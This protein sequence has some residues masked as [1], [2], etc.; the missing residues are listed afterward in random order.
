M[1]KVLDT[2]QRA[3]DTFIG[4]FLHSPSASLFGPLQRKAME[5]PVDMGLFKKYMVQLGT[6]DGEKIREALRSGKGWLELLESRV[7]AVDNRKSGMNLGD[8]GAYVAD[9][10]LH[11]ADRMAMTYGIAR[12]TL[13]NHAEALGTNAD[14]VNAAVRLRKHAIRKLEP[15]NVAERL[16]KD[17]GCFAPAAYLRDVILRREPHVTDAWNGPHQLRDEVRVD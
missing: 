14:L 17:C 5:N 16:A 12:L 2:R 8:A 7:I 6:N 9:L 3:E 4:Y 11:P 13:A 1:S 15:V 10:S